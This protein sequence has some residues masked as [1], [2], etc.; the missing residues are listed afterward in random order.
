MEQ[1]DPRRIAARH[2]I[3]LAAR[4]IATTDSFRNRQAALHDFTPEVLAAFGEGFLLDDMMRTAAFG[5]FKKKL[6]RIWDFVKRAPEA[7]K[8]LQSFFRIKDISELPRV[9]TEWGKKGKQAL[10]KVLKTLAAKF[11]VSLY[12]TD[13]GKMPGLTDL[14]K[15]IVA[16]SPKLKKALSS[17]NTRVVQP[18]DR[19]IEKHIPTLGRPIKAAIFIWI[20]LHVVEIT[21]DFKAL[22]T[23]FTGGLSL[24]QLFGGFP[25]SAIGALLMTFGL[26]YGLLPV[27]LM[28]RILWLVA[29]KYVEWV[30]GKGLKVHWDRITG[31]RGQRPEL[32]PA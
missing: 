2:L 22:I 15:R 18:L 4:E 6:Q 24:S 16:K 23:G 31:E 19:W 11:P 14:M 27:M 3:R 9:I 25:E 32:V 20:W 26:G 12:F 10:G 8:T 5:N 29:H 28:A 13:R 21:W 1:P 17:I 30:P 7:W